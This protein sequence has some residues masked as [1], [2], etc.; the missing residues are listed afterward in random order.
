MFLWIAPA[1][2]LEYGAG[3]AGGVVGCATVIVQVQ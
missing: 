3:F 2:D 1:F